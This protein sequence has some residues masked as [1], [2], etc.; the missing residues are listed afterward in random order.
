M[1]TGVLIANFGGPQSQA[2]L[3]PF[4]RAL[5]TDVL[6]FGPL[7]GAAAWL[8]ARQRKHKIG[9]AYTH[10]GWSPIVPQS[11]DIAQRVA[12]T[13]GG[14]VPV[15]AGM[16]FSPPSF[17]TA[18]TALK[19]QGVRRV[20]VAGLFP[21]ESTATSRA[22]QK[23]I[24][25]HAGDLDLDFLPP[26]YDAPWYLNALA[27]SIRRGIEATPGDG[28][29]HLLFSPHGLPV[30]YVR[31]GDPYPD[32]VRATV[33]GV[34][35]EL[36]WK[37]PWHLGWQSRVGPT[38]WLEP[39]TLTEVERIAGLGVRR[40]CVVPVSFIC[41]G[42]E[43]LHEIDVELAEHAHRFGLE[44]LHRAPALG[45]NDEALIAGLAETIAARL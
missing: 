20:I 41:E 34:L 3:E 21:H 16:M 4:L 9:P 12:A 31:A 22:A 7:S 39:S 42:I 27:S 40:L 24:L 30:S 13:L 19:R 45:P 28:E 8:I 15:T 6:P 43:T 36:G 18:L 1:T 44:H 38:K 32:Q 11:Q 29:L 33:D 23:L 25:P 10:I 35:A 37:G 14:D 26:F 17:H 5:L 2:E